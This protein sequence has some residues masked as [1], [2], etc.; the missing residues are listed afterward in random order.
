MNVNGL[1]YIAIPLSNTFPFKTFSFHML[2]FN[3]GVVGINNYLLFD[4]A[5]KSNQR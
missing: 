5:R 1:M 4:F 2:R 3:M